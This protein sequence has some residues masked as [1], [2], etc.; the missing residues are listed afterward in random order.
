[1]RKHIAVLL[2]VFSELVFADA[3]VDA[4]KPFLEIMDVNR[5]AETWAFCAASYDMM[6]IIM[7][8]GAPARAQQL[9]DLGSGAKLSI[10]MTLVT[11]DLDPDISLEKFKQLW[12]NAQDAMTEWPQAKLDSM[13][14][15]AVRLGNERAEEF[16]RKINATVVACINNLEAQ[17]MYIESWQELIKSGLLQPPPE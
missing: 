5:Q 17:R 13:L 9:S 1:M 8:E 4:N 16:G 2:L 10:G 7:Q 12:T 6:S 3:Y 15:D 11:K 14:A